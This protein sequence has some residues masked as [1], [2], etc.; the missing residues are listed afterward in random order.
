MILIKNIK[1]FAPQ[2]IGEM[3]ILIIGENITYISEDITLPIGNFPEY[4]TINGEN[5]YAL[6]GIID[7]H[8]HF[9]G[10]GGEGGFK[11]RTNELSFQT[12]IESGI[13]TC[14]GLLGTDGATRSMQNLLAKAYSLEEM[15]ISTYIWTGSY[16]LPL[17][18][19]TNSIKSDIIFIPKIIGVGEVA[20]SD[21]RS[22]HPNNHD[23]IHLA[24]TARNAGLLSGK[25]GITHFH[26]GDG[27]EF[28]SPIKSIIENSNIPYSNILPTHINRN[29]PL[30]KECIDYCKSGGLVDITTGIRPNNDD[31]IAPSHALVTLLENGCNIDNITMSSD[32]GGSMPIFSSDGTLK[33]I[34]TSSPS[35]NLDVFRDLISMGVD[36]SIAIKPFTSSPAKILKLNKKGHIK[37]GYIADIMLLDKDFNLHS[38]I[39]QGKLIIS[40]YSII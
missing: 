22:S 6:P 17:T 4:N 15:G 38:L 10:A 2:N 3:D 1:T 9:A 16:Q 8:I 12:I 34:D 24:S 11:T 18:P 7:L 14:V 19:L 37:E 30:F 29:T 20:L 26:L 32:A 28:L 40:N 5:L 21:H 31:V 39:S 25:C 23:L 27:N 33:S 36:I 13:T 35:T